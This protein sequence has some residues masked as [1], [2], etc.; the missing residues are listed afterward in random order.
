MYIHIHIYIY[1]IYMCMCIYMYI[2]IVYG[3]VVPSCFLWPFKHPPCPPE[4]NFK[5]FSSCPKQEMFQRHQFHSQFFFWNMKWKWNEEWFLQPGGSLWSRRDLS[6]SSQ[7]CLMST[8]ME[9]RRL[10]YNY[11]LC[12]KQDRNLSNDA[13]VWSAVFDW[14]ID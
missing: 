2:C 3:W 9:T 10:Q 1:Y 14:L 11:Q 12:N 6:D 4:L 13:L 5:P 8:N 7:W